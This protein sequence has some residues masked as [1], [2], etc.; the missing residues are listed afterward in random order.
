MCIWR[1]GV[2]RHSDWLAD[3]RLSR[4]LLSLNIGA[5][6]VKVLI[7]NRH[8]LGIGDRI[9]VDYLRFVRVLARCRLILLIFTKLDAAHDAHV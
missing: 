6:R 1:L 5:D 7:A 2:R 8:L 4:R 9:L 3:L